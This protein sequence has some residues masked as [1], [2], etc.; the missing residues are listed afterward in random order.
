MAQRILALLPGFKNY[1]LVG[2]VS[3]NQPNDRL[4]TDWYS[5]LEDV[6]T[7]VDLLI[8]FTLPGGPRIAAEW[9]AQSGVALLSG[10]TGLAS[11]DIVALKNAALKIPVLWAPNLSHGV[12]LMTA[13]V[14]QAA[15][16]LD[17]QAGITITDIHHTHK[18]DAPSGTAL[19]LAEAAMEARSERL[20]ELSNGDEGELEFS[21]VRE[22]E[23]VGEHSVSFTLPDELI[24][25]THKALD[26]DVFAKGALK[27]GEWLIT[28]SPGYYSTGDWLGLK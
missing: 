11:S 13:L 2:Q 15:M 19:A 12:A 24:E 18:L 23:V 6:Q 25:V 5:S 3:R 7:P 4:V 9:C 20:D 21:S 27:A 10:T 22:G 28:Q 14:R 17:V 1:E 8:D 26:R 16:A